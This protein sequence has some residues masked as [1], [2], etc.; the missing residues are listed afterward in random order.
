M[1][2]CVNG[3]LLYVPGATRSIRILRLSRQE[4]NLPFVT[5]RIGISS[6]HISRV[7]RGS[8]GSALSR[9]LNPIWIVN[10][11][12]IEWAARSIAGA[13][14][15]HKTALFRLPPV[16]ICPLLPA[17]PWS[18]R[19]KITRPFTAKSPAWLSG[20]A[21]TAR[22]PRNPRFTSSNVPP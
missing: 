20:S 11:S 15:C 22:A 6:L 2:H 8:P 17:I 14:F 18:V 10:S 7:A 5:R 21:G 13:H 19:Q 3:S 4:D 16:L 12:Q 1:K 9:T